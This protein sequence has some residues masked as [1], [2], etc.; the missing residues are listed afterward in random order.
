MR[1]AD[2]IPGLAVAMPFG[3]INSSHVK[4]GA[5][6]I[7]AVV[8][9]VG[10]YRLASQGSCSQVAAPAFQKGRD[11]VVVLR[12]AG[13]FQRYYGYNSA[14]ERPE[15]ITH[16]TEW[17][18]GIVDQSSIIPWADY[19]VL[20]AEYQRVEDDMAA[21]RADMERLKA[22]MVQAIKTDPVVTSF[23][24]SSARVSFAWADEVGIEFRVEIAQFGQGTRDAL[25]NLKAA[26]AAA[27]KRTECKL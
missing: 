19:E 12:K 15:V 6:A 5:V 24:G 8:L 3:Y 16:D 13:H 25:A 14:D 26:Y 23:P 17:V 11:K 9:A 21:A 22:Q 2:I 7:P 27:S 10:Q 18:L 4:G 1:K 20:R